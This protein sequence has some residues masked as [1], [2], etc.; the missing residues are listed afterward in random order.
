M[1]KSAKL[2]LVSIVT[3]SYNQAH[4]LEAT[5]RSV[6]GQDYPNL[7]YI[8]VDGGSTDGSV[9]IIRKYADRFVYWVSEP[10]QGQADAINKGFAQANGEIFAWLNS[11]DL[12]LPGAVQNAVAALNADSNSSLVYAD[13]QSIDAAGE[14]FN[15]IRYRA[16]TLQDLL[17]FRIIGQPSVFF[18]RAAFERAGGLDPSYR[19]LLDHYLWLRIAQQTPIQYVPQTWAAARH[20]PAAKNVAQAAGFADEIERLQTWASEQPDLAPLV[21]QN[22]R[23]VLGGAQRLRGR[24]L[25]DARRPARALGAYSRALFAD[26]PFALRHAHRMLYA[27][28]SL[29]GLGWLR[30]RPAYERGA[31]ILVTGLHRSGTTWVGR[32]LALSGQLAYV[33]EPLNVYHRRGVLD[34]PVEHWYRYVCAENEGDLLPAFRQT[35][36]LRYHLSRELLS[37][38]SPKDF[39]RMLRDWGIFAWGH[40]RSQRPLLKDPFAVFS[41]EWFAERLGAEV[42]IVLRHPAAFVSSLKRLGWSFDFNDLLA[43]PLLMRAWLEP[44]HK[45]MEAL[46]GA[47]ADIIAQGCLLWRAIA[48]TALELKRR[49]PTFHLLKHEELSLDPMT[50]FKDL[51]E[52]LGLPFTPRVQAGIRRATGAGNPSEV[53]RRWIYS[54]RLDS[55][56]NLENWKHR[57]SPEEIARVHD[58][59]ADLADELYSDE[60]WL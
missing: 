50:H 17:A 46:A 44:F 59:T 43:Q 14:A 22:R 6:L 40:L 39:L 13:L 42:V 54:T 41:A 7:E 53:S 26:P 21:V 47:P 10:D 2:P 31:S 24:Y 19:Y 11:D 12:Y 16:Y 60:D 1:P 56:A 49:H 23:R 58:L 8:V 15:T 37:L 9:E 36:R 57:L 29:L 32:M 51:Y 45:D 35:L 52:Q 5:I 38:H 33:S 55:A 20:H 30:P 28:L 48:H 4:Y 27:L 25:L 34:A 3:P 18:R